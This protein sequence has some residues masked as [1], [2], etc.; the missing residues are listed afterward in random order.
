MRRLQN[1]HL[2]DSLS[3]VSRATHETGH[4]VPEMKEEGT[5]RASI[6]RSLEK[7]QFQGRPLLI[8]WT[9]KR[10][11]K[12]AQQKPSLFFVLQGQDTLSLLQLPRYSARRFLTHTHYH[13]RR[14]S[15]TICSVSSKE[16]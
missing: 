15:S 6:G 10:K 12:N 16:K 5:R 9:Q 3:S 14:S 2:A 7:R 1:C 4:R 8:M 13:R 11:T